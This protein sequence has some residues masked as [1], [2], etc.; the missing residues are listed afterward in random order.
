MNKTKVYRVI[1]QTQKLDRVTLS[2][3]IA[4]YPNHGQSSNELLQQADK[5]FIQCKGARTKLHRCY[6]H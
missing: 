3:G 2:I 4:I 6:S 5:A 1:Y